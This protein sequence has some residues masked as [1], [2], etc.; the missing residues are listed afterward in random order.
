VVDASP[1]NMRHVDVSMDQQAALTRHSMQGASITL[2]LLTIVLAYHTMHSPA[3]GPRVTEWPI[4]KMRRRSKAVCVAA[5]RRK[6]QTAQK[7]HRQAQHRPAVPILPGILHHEHHPSPHI[8]T[9]NS[10][11]TFRPSGVSGR[12]ARRWS[13]LYRLPGVGC[14]GPWTPLGKL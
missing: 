7:Q 8:R 12:K 14:S 4:V 10:C 2:P 13:P 1:E 9:L 5:S 3:P 11:S 6:N